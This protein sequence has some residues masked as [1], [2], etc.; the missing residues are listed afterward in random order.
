MSGWPVT[1]VEDFSDARW[2]PVARS[3]DV[4]TGSTVNAVE[5]DKPVA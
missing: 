1:V 3:S 2:M 4:V 5:D